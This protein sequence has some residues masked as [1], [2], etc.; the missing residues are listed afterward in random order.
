MR[1]VTVISIAATA[2]VI[3]GRAVAAPDAAAT[4]SPSKPAVQ[5]TLTYYGD[6]FD[7]A[8]GGVRPGAG[9][10]GRLGLII[11][12]DLGE[13][14]GWSGAALH[15]SVHEIHGT[16][17]SASHLGNLMT[18]SG[19][20]AR[21]SIRLFNLWVEQQIGESFSV[22]V[23]QFTAAQ[24][25]LVSPT[26]N[27][28]VNATFGWPA[29][30]ASD[31]PSGGPSYP[32]AT[33]GVRVAFT[34]GRA[35]TLRAAVFDGDP[36]GPGPGDPVQ[37]D[38][39]GLAFRVRDPPFVIADAV[40]SR[41]GSAGGNSTQEGGA[42]GAAGPA[43]SVRVGAWLHAGRFADQSRAAGGGPLV[44]NATPLQHRSDFGVYAVVDQTL[45]RSTGR[46]LSAFARL[47]VAPSDRNPIDL[48]ADGGLSVAAPFASRPDDN[49]GVALAFA[50]VSPR[51][52]TLEQQLGA[53]NGTGG[54]PGDF[55]MAAEI[56]YQAKISPHWSFQPDLQVILHPG[57]RINQA[58]PGA[59]PP[60]A[61]VVGA[62]V[63]ARY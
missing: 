13:T 61:L 26:A 38:P 59:P 52:S 36:A 37:R 42:T 40:L 21:P 63:A 58:G 47:A 32:E 15:A 33:P 30:M 53:P 54:P 18:V 44:G 7:D 41:G 31:L 48:Y 56:T 16:Q 22:R 17:F 35:L 28:F 20:E 55:E 14:L 2:A 29:L 39:H 62:R 51:L 19:I 60:D 9:Y 57:A 23:G 5:A 43:S 8:T 3:C 27:L 25:F 11:D 12:V 45:W 4:A 50:R 49:F 46:T 34:H 10:D 6:L 1:L 24:E